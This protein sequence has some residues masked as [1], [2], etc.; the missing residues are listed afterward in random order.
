M[1]VEILSPGSTLFQGEAVSIQLPGSS[2]RF[3]I[4]DNHAPIISSLAAGEINV[5]TSSKTETFKI[6]SGF[7]E[8]VKSEVAVLVELESSTEPT[9]TAESN[10][11]SQ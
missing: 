8:V 10:E 6:K 5:R 11:K 7:I 3:E 2:G 4:L 9:K 1:N